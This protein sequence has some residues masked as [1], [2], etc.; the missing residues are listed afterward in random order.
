SPDGDGR[1]DEIGVRYQLP[2]PSAKIT[3]E[4]YDLVGRLIYRPA[5]NLATAAE[6]VI[7]WNGDSVYGDKARVGIYLVRCYAC[8][9]GSSKS[10]EYITTLVLAR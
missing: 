7:Y 3:L 4:V 5:K 1:D 10:V 9:A 6:G 2:Y 8:D